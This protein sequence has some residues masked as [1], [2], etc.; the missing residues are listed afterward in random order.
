[1]WVGMI[2]QIHT[3]E[4]FVVKFLS[5]NSKSRT[6]RAG[7]PVGMWE[8]SERKRVQSNFDL[9]KKGPRGTFPAI[10]ALDER[11]GGSGNG[12]GMGGEGRKNCNGG[13]DERAELVCQSQIGLLVVVAQQEQPG[14]NSKEGRKEGACR[15][16][17]R[18]RERG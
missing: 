5:T 17:G 2:S 6:Y 7:H 4:V 3:V 15:E 8:K 13:A 9:A 10:A 11:T 1:M 12:G 14:R 16:R 18:E